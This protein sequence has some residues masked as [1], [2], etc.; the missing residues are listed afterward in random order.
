MELTVLVERTGDGYTARDP[1][2]RTATAPTSWGAIDALQAAL[3]AA[4]ENVQLRVPHHPTHDWIGIFKDDPL[5]D[6]W[7]AAIAEN[8]RIQ[9]AEDAKRL[10]E[11]EAEAERG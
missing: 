7:V 4:G 1:L 9:D 2:G 6:E 3:T 5:Y 11:L 8:R 10:A